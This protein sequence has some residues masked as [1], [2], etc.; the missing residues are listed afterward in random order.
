MSTIS[1]IMP[2]YNTEKYLTLAI[3]SVLSQSYTD[4]ELIIIDD[5]ST[6]GSRSIIEKYSAIDPRIC[7]IYHTSN[8]QICR[9]L[10]DGLS[11][12]KG[13]Y[14][15]RIDSDDRAYPNWIEKLYHHMEKYKEV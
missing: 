13:R 3:E 4:F 8:Q 7:P 15:A 10:N 12:A 14:I 1:I 2:V 5:A 11:Q 9:S 6:D